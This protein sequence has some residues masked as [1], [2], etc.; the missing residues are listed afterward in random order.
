MK[1]SARAV[2]GARTSAEVQLDFAGGFPATGNGVD[3]GIVR[4]QTANLRFDWEHTSIVAGQDS[5]FISPLS[6]TS[7]ASL[8]TPAF[9]FAGNL[10]GWTPQLRVEHRFVD[11]RPANRNR[12]GRNSRQSRL[13]VSPRFVLSFSASRRTVGTARLRLPHRVVAAGAG[14]SSQLRR[15][16]LLWPPK[17]DLGPFRQRLGWHGGLA[18]SHS[19]PLESLR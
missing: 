7:F 16:R 2:A 5:L 15:R 11:L 9:A 10:W 4:L 19:F 18:G 3:F 8:A 13:G 12:A 14:A 1:S 17:L 6:P